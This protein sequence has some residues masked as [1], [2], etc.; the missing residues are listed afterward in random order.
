[1]RL[2]GKIK[3]GYYPTPPTVSAAIARSLVPAAPGLVRVID[4][5]CG[6]GTALCDTTGALDPVERY[7]IELHRG[8]AEAAARALTRVIH[9]DIRS[10]RV[11]NGAFGLVFL[12]PPYDYDT[13]AEPDEATRRL[14]LVFLQA[15]LRYLQPNG[16]LVFVLPDRRLD[17]RLAPV[18]AQHLRDLQVFRFPGEEY[19]RFAQVVLFGIRKDLP[20][21]DEGAAQIL[22]AVGHGLSIP[23]DLPAA[24]DPPYRVPVV[25]AVHP[26]LF[27][28]LAVDPQDLVGEIEQNGAYPMLL[29]LLTP[30][31]GA[32]GFRPLMPLRRGHLALVLASGHLNNE[33]VCDPRTGHP[34]LIKGRTEKAS[35]RS[36]ETHAD[37]SRTITERDTLKIVITALDLRTG[38]LQT[39]Q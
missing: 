37:G 18:L 28:R 10:V 22:R 15:A 20:C 26:L 4:P 12:N 3:L 24:L 30:S 36:E 16:I 32:E 11:A 6:D 23:A 5:C 8:R 19:D 17:R 9:A 1:V 27:Q 25:P 31:A 29:R 39:V 38:T 35:T 34:V 33:L 2:A 14:E 21:R 13:K 7:G